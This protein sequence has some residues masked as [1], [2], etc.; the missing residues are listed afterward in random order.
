MHST[1]AR[2]PRGANGETITKNEK[3][4]PKKRESCRPSAHSRDSRSHAAAYTMSHPSTQP[5]VVASR[6]SF[7]RISIKR[8]PIENA[9][10]LTRDAHV[11]PECHHLHLLLQ[12][13]PPVQR[14]ARPAPQARVLASPPL[15]PRHTPQDS[16]RYA[17]RHACGVFSPVPAAHVSRG[18]HVPRGGA[19]GLTRAVSRGFA[20]VP[21]ASLLKRLRPCRAGRPS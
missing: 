1:H 10:K 8:P 17:T 21:R 14:R 2:P 18:H 19:H 16:T 20:P 3:V 4:A 7:L 11:T 5:R 13:T 12:S 9:P 15:S 6:A